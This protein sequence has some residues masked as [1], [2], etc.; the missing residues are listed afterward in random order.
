MKD[1]AKINSYKLILL[2]IL[3]I[4]F[5]AVYFASLDFEE[6]RG[7]TN[8]II[9]QIYA[10]GDAVLL[11]LFV[12]LNGG[13]SKGALTVDMIDKSVDKEKAEKTVALISHTK[14]LAKPLMFVI[15]PVTF[16]LFADVIL[17]F[18]GDMIKSALDGL[19]SLLGF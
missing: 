19:K 18:W 3:C 17:L 15:I 10:Y 14:K 9:M 2:V 5:A 8:S 6:A 11:V 7:Y 4:V 12:I 13:F 1:R 16:T